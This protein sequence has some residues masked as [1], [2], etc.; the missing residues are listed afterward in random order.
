[1]LSAVLVGRI[2]TLLKF[3]LRAMLMLL[4]NLCGFTVVPLQLCWCLARS[5]AGLRPVSSACMFTSISH[6]FPKFCTPT[7]KKFVVL[8]KNASQTSI[9]CLCSKTFCKI[10]DKAADDLSNLWKSTKAAKSLIKQQKIFPIWEKVQRLQVVM[11]LSS[12]MN[13][14]NVYYQASLRVKS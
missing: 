12:Q 2:C 11:L 1:M 5:S 8:G 14:L 7:Q 13:I 10:L 9:G 4:I 3:F 6:P